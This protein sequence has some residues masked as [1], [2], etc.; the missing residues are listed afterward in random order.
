MRKVRDYSNGQLSWVRE[1]YV[2]QRG[3]IRKFSSH[4][5]L[6]F[7]ESYKYQQ[8]TLNK[9]LENLPSLYLENCKSG[10]C[11]ESVESNL[12][13]KEDEEEEEQDIE[14]FDNYI[15]TKITNL[16]KPSRLD[17][18]LDEQSVYFTPSEQS[19]SPQTPC[20]FPRGMSDEEN[21]TSTTEPLKTH[22]FHLGPS[23]SGLMTMHSI[24]M[25]DDDEGPCPVLQ[26]TS[27]DFHP[28]TSL[29][30]MRI[31]HVPNE[32][33]SSDEDDREI[34]RYTGYKPIQHDNPESDKTR[35]NCDKNSTKIA[36]NVDMSKMVKIPS[37]SPSPQ[38]ET[39]L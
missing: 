19:M 13:K 29:P 16:T 20:S 38:N 5:V 12:D 26:G 36:Q 4:Q 22:F 27:R 39:A 34:S 9:I 18:L 14:K 6:W 1:N 30:T 2:F 23:V 15:K 21:E 10:S 37:R 33:S 8:Q 24:P 35:H 28:S 3:R 11:G 7:R 17:E 31:N 32:Y 25:I